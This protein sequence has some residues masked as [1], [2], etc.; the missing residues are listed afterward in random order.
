MTSLSTSQSLWN[1]NVL[2][3]E[4]SLWDP[5]NTNMYIYARHKFAWISVVNKE[6]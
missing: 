2:S 3:E 1:P 5:Q 4:V 6:K